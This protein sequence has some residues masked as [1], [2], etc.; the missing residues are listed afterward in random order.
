MSNLGVRASGQRRVAMSRRF[1][2][3]P[4]VERARARRGRGTRPAASASS[5][6]TGE[7]ERNERVERERMTC[8]GHV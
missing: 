1:R 6:K 5:A 7:G 8:G 2:E 4:G 3:A